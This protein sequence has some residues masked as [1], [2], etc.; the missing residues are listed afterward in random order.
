[1]GKLVA[2]LAFVLNSIGQAG[3][4]RLLSITVR[5]FRI[6]QPIHW[7]TKCIGH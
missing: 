2:E 3:S 1:V 5:R 7:R 6:D 4:A